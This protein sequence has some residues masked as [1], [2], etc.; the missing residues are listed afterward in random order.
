MIGFGIWSV[1][2]LWIVLKLVLHSTMPNLYIFPQTCLTAKAALESC[3][4][5]RFVAPEAFLSCQ[6]LYP[7]QTRFL[8][9]LPG[10]GK[11]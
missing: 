6:L 11:E 7:V 3:L 1:C 2:Y 8:K 4:Y 10:K 9:Y 5:L